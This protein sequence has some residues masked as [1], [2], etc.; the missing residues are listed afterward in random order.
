[1]IGGYFT[2]KLGRDSLLKFDYVEIIG[3]LKFYIE[4]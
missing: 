4:V 2:Q 3:E 1:M